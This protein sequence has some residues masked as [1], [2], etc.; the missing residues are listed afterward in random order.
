MGIPEFATAATMAPTIVHGGPLAR[1]IPL[2]SRRGVLQRFALVSA[3]A[4][5]I[6]PP[7]FAELDGISST[8]SSFTSA[9]PSWLPMTQYSAP[10][11]F[12]DPFMLYLARYL[13]RFDAQ[14]ARWYERSLGEL[15][16]SSGEEQRGRQKADLISGFAASLAYR[17]AHCAGAGAGG[18]AEL[19]RALAA[20]YPV[21]QPQL[22]LLFCF[23]APADQP[24]EIMRAAL[25]RAPLFAPARDDVGVA[26][27]LRVPEALLPSSTVPVWDAT[28][29]GFRL[30]GSLAAAA[31]AALGSLGHAPVSRE[32]ALTGSIYRGFAL[33]GGCGCALTHLLVVPLDVVKTRLQ[34]RP[35]SYAGFGDALH[36]IRK[37]EGLGMLFRGSVATGGGYLSYGACLYP[38]YEFFQRL[39]FHWAGAEAVTEG[40]VPLVLLSGAVATFFTCFAITPFEA[41]RIR[42]VEYPTYAPSF[43]GAA[44]RYVREGGVASLYDGLLP[45]LVRQILFGMVKF[46][47]FDECAQWIL[48]TLPA[49]AADQA[50]VSL[51]VSL[52]SGAVAGVTA[53]IVSQPADVVLSKVAQ[54]GASVDG[55][56]RTVGKLPGSI[57]QLA[58]LQRTASQIWREFGLGG[59]FLG[60]PS[61]MVWSSAIIAG[62]FFLYDLFKQALHLST[63]DLTL[64]Y[65][66]FGS[67]A[68]FA[69]LSAA[70]G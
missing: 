35:G 67:S 27:A 56:D 1:N 44:T 57:N 47:I 61:R 39:F 68:A 18:A 42:M 40:R 64:F 8:S 43:V 31:T 50:S 63:N 20:A 29:R 36:T 10:A 52:L 54:E 5:F 16:S 30:P 24:T 3:A 22:P 55:S 46:L 69:T 41:V 62:Q 48:A 7:A 33:S 25:E 70:V 28:T 51:V 59:L 65:D 6:A 23:L 34:T 21:A 38:G 13:I 19:W 49:G 66:A 17:L 37:E 26:D 4:A 12:S 45:L 32:I 11:S 14:S 58:L 53:A 9:V 2:L 60:L 15:P